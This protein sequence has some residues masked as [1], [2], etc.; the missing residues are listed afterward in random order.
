MNPWPVEHASMS[1]GT[2]CWRMWSP[3]DLAFSPDGTK[4]C[5][6]GHGGARL[7][8]VVMGT[9]EATHYSPARSVYTVAWLGDSNRIVTSGSNREIYLWSISERTCRA[10]QS[11]SGPGIHCRYVPQ[12]QLLVGTV[13][14]QSICV[15]DARSMALLEEIERHPDLGIHLD[16]TRY[17]AVS[18]TGERLAFVDDSFGLWE[19][20]DGNRLKP[21]ARDSLGGGE[22]VLFLPDNETI[23]VGTREGTIEL[24]S[25]VTGLVLHAFEAHGGKVHS[26][27]AS[28]DGRMLYSGGSDATI[29]AWRIGTWELLHE[30]KAR[31]G[32][33]FSLAVSPDGTKLAS[34]GPNAAINLWPLPLTQRAAQFP[35]DSECVYL[36]RL[37]PDRRWIVTGAF[38]QGSAALWNTATG[39]LERTLDEPVTQIQ[40]CFLGDSQTVATGQRDGVIRIW[41][42]GTGKE[43]RSWKTNLGPINDLD[44]AVDGDLLA[45]AHDEH[46]SA[47]LWNW[48]EGTMCQ[49]LKRAHRG[50][51]F[52]VRFVPNSRILATGAELTLCLWDIDTGKKL[53]E[54]ESAAPVGN[55]SISRTG[56][57]VCGDRMDHGAMQVWDIRVPTAPVLL[58]TRRPKREDWCFSAAAISPDGRLLAYAIKASRGHDGLIRIVRLPTWERLTTLYGHDQKIDTL[59]FSLDGKRLLSGSWDTTAILWDVEH[60]S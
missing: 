2:R 54:P 14:S 58:A 3:R 25:A 40:S 7:F 1:F 33:I 57:L 11:V 41:E 12:R 18:P 10:S 34:G 59:E 42:A 6:A 28:P 52:R 32:H 46:E 24:R 17:V 20:T 44:C 39:K 38:D 13:L 9:V 27:A 31:G 26:L 43:I 50:R 60:L 55:L 49:R 4:L 21:V 15:W 29:R 53:S 35:P 22:S 47:T 36:P 23:A 37:S 48:R 30:L 51:V 16:E 56:L 45:V 8:D 19:L 5:A